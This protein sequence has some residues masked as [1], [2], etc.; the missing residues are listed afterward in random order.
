MSDNYILV[1][2]DTTYSVADIRK[3][4]SAVSDFDQTYRYTLYDTKI[5]ALKFNKPKTCE[6]ITGLIANLEKNPIVEF[7]HYTMTSN[8]CQSMYMT[9]MGNLCVYSYCNLFNVEVF[10]EN[11]L[12]SLHKMIAETNTELVEQNA[13]MPNWFTL[14][15][16]KNSKGDGLHMANYFYE[17]KLFVTAE[18]DYTKI[19]VE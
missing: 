1:A 4:I 13:F 14:K 18:P 6:E 15:A 19:P 7:A 16:T 2:F 12:T 3:F 11:E 8:D 10:D 5:A 9:P 17:S